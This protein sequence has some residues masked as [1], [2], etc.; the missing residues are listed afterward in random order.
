MPK[1]HLRCLTIEATCLVFIKPS[2]LSLNGSRCRSLISIS[3][4]ASSSSSGGGGGDGRQQ[5][6]SFEC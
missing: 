2:E 1:S 4:S 5:L 6:A 3:I